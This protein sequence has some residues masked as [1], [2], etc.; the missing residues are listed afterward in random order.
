[1]DKAHEFWIAVTGCSRDDAD[2]GFETEFVAE[3]TDERHHL[4][5]AGVG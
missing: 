3:R 1:M 4:D 2:D 5:R